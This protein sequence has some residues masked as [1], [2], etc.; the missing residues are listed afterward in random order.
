[1]RRPLAPL[2]RPFP[3]K[4]LP[5]KW[6]VAASDSEMTDGGTAAPSRPACEGLGESGVGVA[7]GVRGQRWSG[8]H[9]TSGGLGARG[10]R[11]AAGRAGP[12]QARCTQGG[13][14]GSTDLGPATLPGLD[15]APPPPTPFV[16]PEIPAPPVTSLR[17]SFLICAWGRVARLWAPEQSPAPGPA[18]V[19]VAAPHGP[20]GGGAAAADFHLKVCAGEPRPAPTAPVTNTNV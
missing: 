7:S 19:G 4:Q 15:P 14:V 17:L 8:V 11:W 16:Q 2:S 20:L 6:T 10:P 3:L 9:R 12:A 1:M 18:C 5:G 13:A